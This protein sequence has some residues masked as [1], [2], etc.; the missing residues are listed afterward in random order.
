MMFVKVLLIF[1]RHGVMLNQLKATF[2][3]LV[4]K[5]ENTA[6]PDRFRP[7]SL[8][9]ELYEII[10]CILVNR[11]KPIIGKIIGPMQSAFIPG[12]NIS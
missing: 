11:L 8:T 4:P 12:R 9:N 6:S 10:S 3:V 5:G 7:I 2:I 1:F